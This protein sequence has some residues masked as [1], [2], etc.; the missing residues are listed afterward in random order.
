M[1]TEVQLQLKKDEKMLGYLKENSQWYKELNRDPQN[2]KK[3]VAAMK[4]KYKIRA[5]DKIGEVVENI[6]L[7][8]SVLNVIS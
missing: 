4:E 5:T 1:K 6:E 2:Y 7:V 3:F 8:T